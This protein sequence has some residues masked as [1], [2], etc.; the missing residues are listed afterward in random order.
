MYERKFWLNLS[1]L[2]KA[3]KKIPT[4]WNLCSLISFFGTQIDNTFLHLKCLGWFHL[5]LASGGQIL[6][7]YKKCFFTIYHLDSVS[8]H[9]IFSPIVD[10]HRQPTCGTTCGFACPRHLLECPTPD[11]Y[12]LP[13]CYMFTIHSNKFMVNFC[14]ILLFTYQNLIT[15]HPALFVHCFICMNL[16]L[17]CCWWCFFLFLQ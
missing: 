14:L 12:L 3:G 2:P 1:T 17:S 4:L 9:T 15:L 16:I 8:M 13:S 11:R 10:E 7:M 5:L 6:Q